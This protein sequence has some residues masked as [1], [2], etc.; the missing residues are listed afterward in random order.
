MQEGHAALERRLRGGVAGDREVHRAEL[1]AVLV[2]VPLVRGHPRRQGQ[3][4][5]RRL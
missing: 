1:L 2:G 4:H 3:G 5:H